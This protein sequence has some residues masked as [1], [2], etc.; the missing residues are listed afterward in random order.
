MEEGTAREARHTLVETFSHERAAGT[1]LRNLEKKLRACG[2]TLSPIP[3]T[4]VFATLEEQ[5]WIDPFM[6]LVA[7]FLRHFKGARLSHEQAKQRAANMKDR[8]RAE[9]F[10]AVFRPIFE[11]YEE[12]LARSGQIDFHDMIARAT[13][14]VEAG[15]YRSPFGYI[16]VDEFQDISPDRA[17][18]LKA[19]L[20]RSPGAQLFAVGDDWQAIFRF[21]GSDI[22]IM[23]EF[24]Q[25]FG[26]SERLSLE[27]TFRCTD[28]IAAVATD[29]ILRNPAQIQKTV[30]S[31]HRAEGPCV[32][33]GLPGE[34]KPSLLKEALDRIAEDASQTRRNLDRIAVGTV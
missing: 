9:A 20:D 28:R 33:V 15:R 11:R 18:L 7:T 4:E 23:R 13:E 21:A 5:G 19:L 30:R 10:L 16:L 25:H 27:T 17:R 31:I 22:G 8:V 29:F 3:P 2:V 24:S 32:H 34:Q 26:D 6:S 14:H 1:L 12:T